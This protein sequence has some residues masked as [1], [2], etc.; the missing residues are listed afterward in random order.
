[1]VT[2]TTN[3]RPA[4]SNGTVPTSNRMAKSDSK[5]DKASKKP[6]ARSGSR[7]T[8]VL[9]LDRRDAAPSEAPM[10]NMKTGVAVGPAA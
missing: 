1:M 9:V 3:H 10:R 8:N 6:A 7:P 4:I 5:P 2:A